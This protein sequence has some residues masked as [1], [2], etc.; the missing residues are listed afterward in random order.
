MVRII[1][2]GKRSE[3]IREFTCFFC[4]CVFE[5]DEYDEDNRSPYATIAYVRCPNCN[6]MMKAAEYWREPRV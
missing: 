1:K 3:A 5:T 4:D 2:P 6:R